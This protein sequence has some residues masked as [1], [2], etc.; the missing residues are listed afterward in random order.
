MSAALSIY[1]VLWG[2]A[3]LVFALGGAAGVPGDGSLSLDSTVPT[4]AGLAG[5]VLDL[6]V[7]LFDAAAVQGLTALGPRAGAGRRRV[8]LLPEGRAPVRSRSW[9]QTASFTRCA[10][11]SV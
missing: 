2:A 10:M 6:Q 1:E 5:T 11:K 3:G 7:L 8:G 9:S 4:D